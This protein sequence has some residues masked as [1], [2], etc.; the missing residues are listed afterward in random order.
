MDHLLIIRHGNTRAVE[1]WLYC[2]ST[3]LPLSP[4]GRAELEDLKAA[5][6]W[7][8]LTGWSIYTSGMRR[9]EETL[10]V[11]F[12]EVPHR[13]LP[14]FREIDF[15][16]FEMHSYDELKVRDDYQAWISGDN[17]ANICPGGESGL[18]MKERVLAGLKELMQTSGDVLLLCHGGPTV[19]VMQHLFPREDKTRYDWQPAGGHGYLIAFADGSPVSYEAFPPS[20]G[21]AAD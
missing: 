18:Q 5:H 11:L 15:G 19:T 21:T 8:D 3:D 16:I 20:A 12:G 9:T 6:A 2:G 17:E 1:D 7:P 4:S 14:A 13:T 10:E